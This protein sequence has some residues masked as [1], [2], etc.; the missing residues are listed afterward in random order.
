MFAYN[1][2]VTRIRAFTAELDA[3]GIRHAMLIEHTYVDARPIGEEVAQAVGKALRHQD[4]Q[5]QAIAEP[6]NP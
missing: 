3:F 6:D 5:P 1:F 2:M 4:F